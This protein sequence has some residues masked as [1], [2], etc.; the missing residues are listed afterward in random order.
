MRVLHLVLYSPGNHNY[1][2]MMHA[3]KTWYKQW[4]D[5]ITT[6]YYWYDPTVKEVLMDPDE[7]TLRLPGKDT[8]VGILDKTLDAFRH[9]FNKHDG[10]DFVVR[11]NISTV[12]NLVNLLPIMIALEQ[13]LFYGG[14][15]IME[16]KSV[17]G[18][19][20]VDKSVLPLSFVQG[21]NIILRKD[22]VLH[23]LEHAK[24]LNREIEDDASIGLF[25]REEALLHNKGLHF[26]P[27]Q[28]GSQFAHFSSGY[29]VNNVTAF[30]NHHFHSDRDEDARNVQSEVGV[31][32]QRFVF[33]KTKQAVSVVYYYTNIVT[34]KIV[35][36]C[37]AQQGTWVTNQDNAK[38][39]A[40][41]GDPAPNLLKTLL[42][43]FEDGD[44][45][46]FTQCAN[47]IFSVV[48]NKLF[49][50]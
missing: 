45:Q 23:L 34:E 24:D 39:D 10:F 28:V 37:K 26:L 21:T 9:F 40:L 15:H 8:Y 2:R 32:L 29:N 36:L 35:A 33:L 41:F 14:S 25:F 16:V 4:S 11:S 1:D 22:A 5:R 43:K 3:T 47:L 49:V 20:V 17:S 7:M 6:Y 38:L 12:L 18:S 13:R 42:V 30:R 46:P 31:L 27:Q 44:K 50:N 48:N 19:T